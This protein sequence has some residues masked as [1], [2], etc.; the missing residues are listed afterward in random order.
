MKLPKII[1]VL[2]ITLL[3]MTMFV[4]IN[5]PTVEAAPSST[6][7]SLIVTSSPSVLTAGV[8]S[9]L[10]DPSLPLTIRVTDQDGTP[11]DLTRSADGETIKTDDVWN[12]L[13]RDPHPDNKDFFGSSASLPQYYWTRTDLHNDD[14][15]EISNEALFGKDMIDIDFSRAS[16]GIYIFEG[17][18]ANDVGNFYISVTTPDRRRA[19]SVKIQVKSPIVSYEIVNMDDPDLR[20]F[21]SPDDP[22]FVMT[23]LDN[24]IYNIRVT[25]KD[26]MGNVIRGVSEGVSL[27]SGVKRT[28]RFTP[29]TTRPANYGWS[30][31]PTEVVDTNF[32]SSGTAYF[33]S[34]VGDRYDLHIGL[35]LDNNG[36]LEWTNKELHRFG[37][38]HV[39]NPERRSNTG[40]Y[41]YYNTTN[42]MYK[43]GDYSEHPFFDLP[44]AL[45]GG[46]GLGCIYNS[47]KFD[48]MVM[49]DFNDDFKID[50]RDSLNLDSTGQT[51]FYLFAEDACF[52]GGLVGDS[53]WG[54]YDVAG[55]PPYSETSP[56]Y[57]TSRYRGD[58]TYYL[59]FDA[60]PDNVCKLEPPK[61]KL[62]WA[63]TRE[64]IGKSMLNTDLY[65]LI[66]AAQNHVVA[67]VS[68][69]DERDI[70]IKSHGEVGMVGNQHE[71]AIY[72][73]L[74]YEEAF[75]TT[76]TTIHFTPTGVGSEV[77]EVRYQA[78]NRWYG[79]G[80]DGSPRH[81]YIE[82]VFWIDSV[83]GL[84][85][86]VILD[87]APKIGK[88]S[89]IKILCREL[90]SKKPVPDVL[91]TL[92]GGGVHQ[93][94]VSGIDG[95]A[96]FI[97]EFENTG[98]IEITVEKDGFN[99][100]INT[101]M[102]GADDEP[103]ALE[104]EELPKITRDRNVIIEGITTP[105]SI[106]KI[107]GKEI[108]V[109]SNGKFMKSYTLETGKN[110]I[111][112]T[113]EDESGNLTKVELEVTLDDVPPEILIDD[114]EKQV[115]V[116]EVIISGRVEVG[117]KVRVGDTE[118]TVVNDIF[119]ATIPVVPGVNKIEVLAMDSAGNSNTKEVSV[120]IWHKTVIQMQIDNT[121]VIVDGKLTP[122]LEAPPYI[123]NDRTM[124]PIR[125]ISQGFGATVKWF[126]ED[127]TVAVSLDDGLG[128]ISIIMKIGSKMAFVGNEVIELD[129][130]PEIVNGRTFVPLR[131]VAESLGCEV[132]YQAEERIIIME[133]IAY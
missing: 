3:V 32:Y 38:Q 126:P 91:V 36:K 8:V 62:L 78:E 121:I 30:E 102:V 15:T 6:G 46:W 80:L 23:A 85:L 61:F 44:P 9:E 79:A 81:Y 48:G 12:L 94:E 64:E 129:A 74:E 10:V 31:E 132:E 109:D 51:S 35:D 130:E 53:Y 2:T 128:Q 71:T 125:A 113:S 103:P 45:H 20:V 27:C 111:E 60:I 65:D 4:G 98:E 43:D 56:Q 55:R 133:R 17:F 117:S 84:A 87:E 99:S 70:P 54:D 123:K 73:R 14:N 34:D 124:V 49:S 118:A 104:V 58:G 13:F 63:K 89:T 22:D 5:S 116:D 37:P 50:Y 11:I 1:S 67:I 47:A 28:A 16:E 96:T 112:I 77:I 21:D 18:V 57:I 95:I 39:F 100:G 19:G 105:G 75:G 101:F 88:E 86:E 92:K 26:A 29:F 119:K 108:P 7:Q 110:I 122:T 68:P 52:V 33:L 115:D 97:C 42:Y 83:K 127:R 90:G 25:A 41:T 76:E 93:S 120:T 72:G 24:R 69:A 131:F 66:Y 107:E 82:E 40:Y 59:D 106:V 114:L